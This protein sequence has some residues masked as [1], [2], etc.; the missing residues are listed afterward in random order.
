MTGLL[1]CDS[2]YTIGLSWN[3]STSVVA[4]YNV[5]RATQSGGPY[6]KLNPS[7]VP[8]MVKAVNLKNLESA[9][10]EEVSAVIP[11]NALLRSSE[12][13]RKFA[14]KRLQRGYDDAR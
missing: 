2:A 4:G 3:A 11:G 6:T 10:S 14:S 8:A 13:V 1:G 5:Y 12:V 9:P 7:P